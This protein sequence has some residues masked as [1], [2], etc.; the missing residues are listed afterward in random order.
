MSDSPEPASSSGSAHP[1]GPAP[2][3]KRDRLRRIIPIAVS[4]G[5]LAYLF[6]K[7]DFRDA[8]DFLSFDV[9]LRF[10]GPLVI[11]NL[12]TLFIE[13]ICLS[14]V[15]Q[16]CG[17]ALDRITAAR[18]KAACYLLSLL[19]YAVGAVGLSILLRRRA[20]LSLGDAGGMVFAISL[21]DIGSVL[22][23]AAVGATF[24]V[25]NTVGLRISLVALLI[26]AIVAGFVFLRAPISMGP[27]DRIRELDLFRAARTLPLGTLVE[28]FVLRGL[29]VLCYVALMGALFWAFEV[30]IGV[31]QLAMGVAILLAVSALP[32]AAGGLGT[33]QI[34]F[35]ELF[36]GLSADA[37][38]LAMSILSSAGLVL[39][40]ALL[41]FLF[42]AEFTKEA[43]EAARENPT[44]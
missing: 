8:L 4:A 9:L 2:S 7:I 14:R 11:F 44:D 6:S 17:N 18:I 20:G 12:V 43:L 10:L 16:A 34:V 40:R 26:S 25:S 21:F 3:A 41:G 30:E 19:N 31:F 13:S 1:P 37:E 39:S 24:S 32:I 35:V 29:F 5:L 33:G 15:A 42:A 38:L 22:A 23:V 36:S 27:L 28:L